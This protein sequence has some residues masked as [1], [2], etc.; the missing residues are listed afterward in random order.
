MRKNGR[1]CP[2]VEALDARTLL[3]GVAATGGASLQLAGSLRGRA[4]THSGDIQL[5]FAKG[6]VSPLGEVK[7]VGGESL[8][9]ATTQIAYI[10]GSNPSY[11]LLTRA[12][13]VF[14]VTDIS[15]VGP[16]VF[17]GDYTIQGGTG[18]YAGATGTGSVTVSYLST[19]FIITFGSQA[20]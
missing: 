12:G 2:E 4:L 13:Q 10:T 6:G 20:G 3:S 17:S 16:R 5:F 11:N 15:S 7:T 9:T 14:V 1:R 18:A 8:S 19:R